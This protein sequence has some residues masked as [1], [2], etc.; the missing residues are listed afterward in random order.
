MNELFE[1]GVLKECP[2]C[3]GHSVDVTVD[4]RGCWAAVCNGCDWYG[5]PGSDTA[6][7]IDRWNALPRRAALAAAEQRIREEHD[8]AIRADEQRLMAVRGEAFEKARAQAA[9]QRA[10]KAQP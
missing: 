2:C 6:D 3:E 10:K 9:E 7:A 5:P 8:A 4:Y 1:N